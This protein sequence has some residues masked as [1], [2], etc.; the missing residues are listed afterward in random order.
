MLS[1]IVARTLRPLVNRPVFAVAAIATLVMGIGLNAAVYSVARAALFR[2]LPYDAPNEL[3][4]VTYPAPDPSLFGVSV[5][6][7]LVR[8]WV[9]ESRELASI[10]AFNNSDATWTRAQGERVRVSSATVSP[11]LAPAVT[12]RSPAVGRWFVD[13][14]GLPGAPRVVVI[15]H[16][17]WINQLGGGDALPAEPITLNGRPHTI[18]GVLPADFRFPD[19]LQPDVLLPMTPMAAAGPVRFVNVVG[20][21]RSGSDASTA[22]RELTRLALAASDQFDASMHEIQQ[23]GA[24]PV[25]TSLHRHIARDWTTTIWAGLTAVAIL[26][27]LSCSNVAGLVLTRTMM[28]RDEI[29]TRAA[30]GASVLSIARWLATEVV[31]LVLVA[32]ATALVL[33]QLGIAALNQ[34]LVHLAPGMRPVEID[35]AVLAVAFVTCGVAAIV[36]VGAPLFVLWRRDLVRLSRARALSTSL[37]RT[38]RS[39]LVATQVAAAVALVVG[40]L[41]FAS[42]ARHLANEELG[43]D[44][45]ATLTARIP[46]LGLSQPGS[47]YAEAADNIVERTM[48]LPGVRSAAAGTTLPLGGRSF[49]FQ[50]PIE[51]EPAPTGSEREAPS[52]EAVTPGYF[53]TIGAQVVRG[54]EFLDSDGAMAPHA[55]IVNEAF[56]RARLSAEP[57]PLGRR[58]SLGGTP[59]DATRTI[60]GVV[61]DIADGNPGEP[62]RPTVYVPMRQAA[63]QLGWHTTLLAIRLDDG[64]DASAASA[65]VQGVVRELYPG[66]VAYDVT[67]LEQLVAG[68]V[69][70]ERSREIVFTAFAAAALVIAAAGMLA[71]LLFNAVEDA[72]EIALRIALGASS[73]QLARSV[74]IN[75]AIPTGVGIVAG[76]IVAAV[77][78]RAL[79]GLLH[80]VSPLDPVVYIGSAMVTMMV[81]LVACVLP[82]IRVVRLDP[83]LL[84]RR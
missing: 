26:F 52:V 18:I 1:Q 55:A 80:G 50:I 62:V 38:T 37:G 16:G 63:P 33:L 44:P 67:T 72:P 58:L 13:D 27:V 47:T 64:V 51:G 6:A 25:V 19:V 31:V 68:A 77:S 17:F 2:P 23:A 61:A 39:A 82:V 79:A 71:L 36:A 40:A 76:L 7:P 48:R 8:H 9:A 21:L 14:D 29:A 4:A 65:A 53:A 34:T 60:V 69:A 59:A 28:R 57:N 75:A 24:T 45:S 30:L 11:S 74:L 66:A 43:F 84:L 46:S 78:T 15:S 41:L 42:T 10:A 35:T 22:Q 3:V 5:P 32:G 83:A 70:G 12:R 49:Q 81:G 56:L 54:R 73:V 20:R